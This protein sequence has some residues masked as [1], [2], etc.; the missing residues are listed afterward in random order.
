MSVNEFTALKVPRIAN[1]ISSVAI[2]SFPFD[3]FLRDG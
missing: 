1:F 2:V 3:G